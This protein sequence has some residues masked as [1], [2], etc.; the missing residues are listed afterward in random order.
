MNE[1]IASILK[2]KGWQDI[3]DIFEDEMEA[4]LRDIPTTQTDREIATQYT[5]KKEAQVII[6]KV[7]KRLERETD[8]TII[9]KQSMK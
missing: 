7:F 1:A 9:N 6:R 4:N 8:E 3:I 2:S 5:G